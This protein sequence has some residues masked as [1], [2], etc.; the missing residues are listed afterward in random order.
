[1][2][3][4]SPAWTELKARHH[5]YVKSHYLPIGPWHPLCLRSSLIRRTADRTL[6]INACVPRGGLAVGWWYYAK[7][8]WLSIL[9]SC[10]SVYSICMVWGAQGLC[11]GGCMFLMMFIRRY[12]EGEGVFCANQQMFKLKREQLGTAVK[13]Q[14]EACSF[15]KK[16][17]LFNQHVFYVCVVIFDWSL[18]IFQY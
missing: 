12:F 10:R 13:R 6:G 11:G 3:S 15:W 18:S 5:E 4:S 16:V 2:F 1:M 14:R 8:V 17:L 9:M 7:A